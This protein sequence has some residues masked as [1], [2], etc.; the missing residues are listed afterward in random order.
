[1]EYGCIPAALQAR[2]DAAARW[3]DER[4]HVYND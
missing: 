1:M 2:L 4:V 3:S